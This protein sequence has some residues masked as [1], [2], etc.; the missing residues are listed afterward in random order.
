[1]YQFPQSLPAPYMMNQS[2]G[3]PVNQSIGL[4][5]GGRAKHHKMIIAHFNPKELDILDHLQGKDERCPKSGIRTYTH[6]EELLKNPHIRETVHHHARHHAMGGDVSMPYAH[7]LAA[8]GRHGDTELGLIG[9][10]THHFF[11]QMA[12]HATHN[13]HTG[14]PEYFNLGEALS[15]LWNGIKGGAGW[16]GNKLSGLFGGG[17]NGLDTLREVANNVGNRSNLNQAANPI[18]SLIPPVPGGKGPVGGALGPLSS[19]GEQSLHSQYNDLQ[20]NKKMLNDFNDR[21]LRSGIEA[22]LMGRPGYNHNI[23]QERINNAQAGISAAQNPSAIPPLPKL[24]PKT[25]R[26]ERERFK[27]PGY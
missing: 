14:H 15:G 1:M 9:P 20:K 5:K 4:A 21:N 17:H 11:N 27:T 10:H 8:G 25:V 3:S 6:L 19:S 22:S 12:G 2:Q 23:N 26:I 24:T 18:P 7:H 16:L 13:P